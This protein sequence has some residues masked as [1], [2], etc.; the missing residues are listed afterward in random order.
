MSRK[1]DGEEELDPINFY[2]S[3]LDLPNLISKIFYQKDISRIVNYLL[4][5]YSD[6]FSSYINDKTV[7]CKIIDFTNNNNFL[8]VRKNVK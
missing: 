4:S 2:I 8:G 7:I 6:I 5:T 3:T 1:Y